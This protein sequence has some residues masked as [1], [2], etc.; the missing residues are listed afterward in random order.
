MRVIEVPFEVEQNYAGWRLDRYL[1]QKISRLS[2]ARIQ[3]LIRER[4]RSDTRPLKPSSLVRAGEKFVLLKDVDDETEPVVSGPVQILHEDEQLIVL[5]KPAGLAVHPSARYYHHTITQWLIGNAIRADG[6]KPDLA[7]RLDRETSGVLVCGR[8]LETMRAL[9]KSFARREIEK[10]YLALVI[11]RFEK[12]V[13][14]IDLA[15][16]LTEDVK[17]IMEIHPDGYPSETEARVLR[18]GRLK[19]DQAE[20][21]LLECRPKTGRQ[22]QIRVHLQALGHPIIGDKIYGGSVERFLRFC[23]GD[24]TDEDRIALRLPRHALHAWKLSMP[25]PKTRE[26]IEFTAPL[27]PDL[28]R[29]TDEEVTWET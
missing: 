2:R 12:E 24:Q 19:G 8:G 18:R 10:S 17:V 22:H 21:T 3:R 13:V 23:R 20:V 9:K 4:L 6:I 25:H 26:T 15:M 28:Q 14:T 1:Q 16:R 29:F 27:A 5:D 7:H 11:G